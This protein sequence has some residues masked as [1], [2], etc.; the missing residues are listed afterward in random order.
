MNI[1]NKLRIALPSKGRLRTD[2]ESLF[3]EKKII[4]SNL[5]NDREYIAAIEGLDNA[6]VYFLS[7]KEITNRLDEGS[8]HVGLTGDDLV[9]EKITNYN[10]KV[11]KKLKLNFGKANLVVA[12]P[13]I[14]IDVITMA[15][16]EEI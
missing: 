14:W 15:D 13:E 9:Q 3:E 2:M 10:Q 4:F 5:E 8:I 6:I 1:Q 11:S 7:A 16:L 12:I